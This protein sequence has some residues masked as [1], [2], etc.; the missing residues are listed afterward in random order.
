MLQTLE[1]LNDRGYDLQ[2]L[3]QAAEKCTT[4]DETIYYKIIENEKVVL[5]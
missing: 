1:L 4:E 5:L 3:F 2:S